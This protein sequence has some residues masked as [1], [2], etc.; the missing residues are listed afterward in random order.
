MKKFL[1]VVVCV[2]ALVFASCTTFRATGL[3]YGN[4]DGQIVGHFDK[5]VVVWKYLGESGGATLFD[6]GQEEIDDA[7]ND[8]IRAE[9]MR[10]NADAAID[11]T[12]EEEASFFNM[13]INSI[14]SGV[15]A[16]TTIRVSGTAINLY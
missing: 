8:A 15:L 5:K 3:S 6:L 9:L 12:I 2:L 1:S 14:T 4:F 7:V 16:P 11:V 10:L 13:I